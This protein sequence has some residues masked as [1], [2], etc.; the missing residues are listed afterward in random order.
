MTKQDDLVSLE[1][2]VLW[3]AALEDR[4]ER[5]KAGRRIET[6]CR[7]LDNQHFIVGG[8]D[9]E[10]EI[11]LRA[12]LKILFDFVLHDDIEEAEE[13]FRVVTGSDERGSQSELHQIIKG[14]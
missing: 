12:V 13:D 4:D 5:H 14:S 7:G 10:A 9:T 1:K 11:K 3:A 6:Q 8:L 2:H